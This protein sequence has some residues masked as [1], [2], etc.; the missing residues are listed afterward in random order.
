MLVYLAGS[1]A[2]PVWVL[3]NRFESR[4]S[5][6]LVAVALCGKFRESFER[7]LHALRVAVRCRHLLEKSCTLSGPL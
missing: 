3:F 5:C 7:A 4:S 1:A 6:R 2:F